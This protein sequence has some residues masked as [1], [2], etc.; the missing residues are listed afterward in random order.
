MIE[1]Q[2]ATSVM[3]TTGLILPEV[4]STAFSGTEGVYMLPHHVQ[5]INRLQ[6]QHRFMKSTTDGVQLVV[7]LSKR[8]KVRVLDC[9]CADGTCLSFPSTFSNLSLCN[10]FEDLAQHINVHFAYVPL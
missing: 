1:I 4:K 8:Q 3:P 2:M 9:G 10:T 6:R 7:P 5:E